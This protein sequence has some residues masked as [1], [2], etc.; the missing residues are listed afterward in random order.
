MNDSEVKR[1]KEVRSVETRELSSG[2]I[3]KFQERI[4]NFDWS[5]ITDINDVNEAYI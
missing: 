4:Q 5:Y 3:I 2:N 1:V